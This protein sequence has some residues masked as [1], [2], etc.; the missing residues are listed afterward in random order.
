MCTPWYT[1]SSSYPTQDFDSQPILPP[2]Q[3]NI[4]KNLNLFIFTLRHI[5]KLHTKAIFSLKHASSNIVILD[6]FR[7]EWRCPGK[8]VVCQKISNFNQHHFKQGS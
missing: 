7:M 8:V 2:R 5:S 3:G 4:I 1:G 6:F